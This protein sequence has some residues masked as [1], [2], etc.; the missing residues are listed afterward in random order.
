MQVDA[1]EDETPQSV[2]T[3]AWQSR[4]PPGVQEGY[5]NGWAATA[6]PEERPAASEGFAE[7]LTAA[8]EGQDITIVVSEWDTPLDALFKKAK[9]KCKGRGYKKGYGKG[10]GCGKQAGQSIQGTG[11]GGRVE[12]R[13]C[14]WCHVQGRIEA[15]FRRKTVGVPQASD[16]RPPSRSAN[17]LD[18]EDPNGQ[19]WIEQI[20]LPGLDREV[21]MLYFGLDASRFTVADWISA[22]DDEEDEEQLGENSSAPIGPG[23]APPVGFDFED[24]TDDLFIDEYGID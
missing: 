13:V 2:A 21:L 19:D 10:K 6:S 17:A 14:N 12:T 15:D 18:V 8:A 4:A 7:G 3:P 16:P 1:V 20:A 24:G 5:W 23:L 11:K 22:G 9:G